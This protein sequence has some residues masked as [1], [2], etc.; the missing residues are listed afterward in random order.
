MAIARGPSQF[1]VT[2]SG[3]DRGAS[4]IFMA[5]AHLFYAKSLSSGH[6]RVCVE[7]TDDRLSTPRRYGPTGFPIRA[8]TGE[9][10]DT[11]AVHVLHVTAVALDSPQS[12]SML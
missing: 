12:D 1:R 11:G 5:S 10:T 8:T 2:L 9:I 4:T 6:R 3:I 7:F